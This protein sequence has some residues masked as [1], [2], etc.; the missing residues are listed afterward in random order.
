MLSVLAVVFIV[1]GICYGQNGKYSDCDRLD[2]SVSD[3]ARSHL[4]YVKTLNN[5]AYMLLQQINELE[6]PSIDDLGVFYCNDTTQLKNYYECVFSNVTTCLNEK[7]SSQAKEIPDAETIATGVVKLCN[8]REDMNM[9]CFEKKKPEITE[10]LF[11]KLMSDASKGN[12][13]RCS[14]FQANLACAEKLH[15]CEGGK[16]FKDFMI[17]ARPNVCPHSGSAPQYLS[18]ALLVMGILLARIVHF[19]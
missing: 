10:C 3:C 7:K 8:N 13:D 1:A 18:S 16:V 14:R 2:A 12:T 11:S 15:D 9:S 17:S 6:D 5:N 4:Q 19:Q